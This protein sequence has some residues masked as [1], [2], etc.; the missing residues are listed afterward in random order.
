MA[1]EYTAEVVTDGLLKFFAQ[2]ATISIS[3][4]PRERFRS[5]APRA[6]TEAQ[7]LLAG[8]LPSQATRL[9]RRL[10]RA[11]GVLGHQAVERESA[12][13]TSRATLAAIPSRTLA[14][15]N[16]GNSILGFRHVAGRQRAPWR[17]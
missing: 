6:R 1:G 7:H 3:A 5:G 16:L 8:S 12:R 9:L 17:R 14:P 4:E 11:S 13:S 10:P 2:S 15:F